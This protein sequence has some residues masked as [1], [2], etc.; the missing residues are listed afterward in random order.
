MDMALG[1]LD[2]LRRRG[3]RLGAV[4]QHLQP[5]AQAGRRAGL[6]PQ[7]FGC[8]RER[9]QLSVAAQPP[10]VVV[11]HRVLDPA[12]LAFDFNK[13]AMFLDVE[14][15]RN[16]YIDP[17][18]ARKESQRKLQAH[19]AFARSACQKLGI[20]YHRFATDRPMELALFDFLRSRMQRGKRTQRTAAVRGKS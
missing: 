11:D 4:D 17:A 14:S 2:R 18:M 1:A 6:R 10:P 8:G 5:V 3:Q 16:L 19:M 20:A 7:P 13:A 15:G 12:E 9:A